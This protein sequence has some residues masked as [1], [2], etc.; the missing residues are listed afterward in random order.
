VANLERLAQVV[1]RL[2]VV[3]V[4]VSRADRELEA[5]IEALETIGVDVR[6]WR[7]DDDLAAS[8]G[9]GGTIRERAGAP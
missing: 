6:P 7:I 5:F 2:V 3:P 1:T 4:E 9:A 8:L